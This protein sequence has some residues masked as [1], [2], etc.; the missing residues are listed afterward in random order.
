MFCRRV[1]LD[2][3]G[4]V[5]TPEEVVTFLEDR[6]PDKRTRLIDALLESPRVRR[7]LDVEMGRPAGLQPA[8]HGGEGG[9]RFSSLDPRPD[10]RQCAARPVRPLGHHGQ[11]PELHA[12]ARQLLPPGPYARGGVET[13]SQV[14]LGVR[15]GLRQ[16]PQ[17]R[18][19]ALD[20]GRLLRDGRVF[21]PGP[22]QERAAELCAVQQG[23]DRLSGPRRRDP[24]AP[25]RGRHGS[26]AAGLANRP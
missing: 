4:L 9:H 25:H 18:R 14:F 11:G 26:Q 19:G 17:P 24:P 3:I 10:R 12:S 20:A 8:V 16:V 23:R 7:L 6:R 22:V 2:L 15:I 5:P 13:V 1:Y 21:Q